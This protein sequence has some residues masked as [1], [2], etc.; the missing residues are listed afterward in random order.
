MVA[1]IPC[2]G[3]SDAEIEAMSIP[4]PLLATEQ[5][6]QGCACLVDRH[7]GAALTPAAWNQLLKDP[8]EDPQLAVRYLH[9]RVD[10]SNQKVIERLLRVNPG[11]RNKEIR[12]ADTWQS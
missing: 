1:C 8:S 5:L 11:D 7:V 10:P 9:G 12:I 4:G 6:L 2:T 3:F